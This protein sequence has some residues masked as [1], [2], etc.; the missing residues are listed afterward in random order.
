[1]ASQTA[2]QCREVEIAF[3]GPNAA[4]PYTD[5]D[6][7]TAGLGCLRCGGPGPFQVFADRSAHGCCAQ[8]WKRPPDYVPIECD[9][10]EP[11]IL[12]CCETT[13]AW[14]NSVG[15]HVE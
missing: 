12:I 6:P 13:P 11:S 3:A 7:S 15:D 9:R 5:V 1:M 10:Y 14:V 4:D 2:P 8:V